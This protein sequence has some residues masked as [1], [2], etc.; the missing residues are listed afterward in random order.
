MPK[1]VRQTNAHE[2]NRLI[3]H[4]LLYD[5][6]QA[7]LEPEVKSWP[8]PLG[9]PHTEKRSLRATSIPDGNGE[10]VRRTSQRDISSQ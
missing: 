3:P 10:C 9:R 5:V 8:R 1:S 4:V 2:L 6:A 7:A